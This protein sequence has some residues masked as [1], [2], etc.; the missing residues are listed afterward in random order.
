M[1]VTYPANNLCGTLWRR[2]GKRKESLQLHLWNFDSSSNTPVAP[3]RLSCQIAT[4][5]RKGETSANIN[6]HWKTR[7]KGNDVI[8]NVISAKHRLFRFR[9]SNSRDA[10]ASCPS[11][12]CPAAKAY[13]KACS[14]ASRDTA[15][16]GFV[17]ML[18]E[19]TRWEKFLEARRGCNTPT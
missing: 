6:K 9:Y 5:Q 10:V 15:S 2:S 8:T 18:L 4:N 14:Q 3:R 11:F 16:L 13:R 12:S 1:A 17:E 7:P 19:M